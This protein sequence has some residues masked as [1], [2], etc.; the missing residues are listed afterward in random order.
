[1]QGSMINDVSFG[2]NS[3]SR[4]PALNVAS[5]VDLAVSGECGG[6]YPEP[7]ST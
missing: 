5:F 2:A 3:Q 7:Q 6:A 1:M 4:N